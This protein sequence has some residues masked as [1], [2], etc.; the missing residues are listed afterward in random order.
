MAN[1][2]LLPVG[3]GFLVGTIWGFVFEKTK[4]YI[5]EIVQDQMAMGNFLMMKVFLAGMGSSMLGFAALDAF[6]G[7]GKGAYRR[8]EPPLSLGSWRY[9][10]NL[11]GGALM[12]IGMSLGG[13]CP[14]TAFV[15]LAA[16]L[17]SAPYAIAGGL[18]GAL[19]FGY[20]HAPLRANVTNYL[21]PGEKK[22]LDQL[23]G[24]P[25][26]LFAVA[27][28]SA[29]IAASFSLDWL[30]GPWKRELA[31]VVAFSA[32][33]SASSAAS[34]SAAASGLLGAAAWPP[35]A[36]C[37]LFVLQ[38]LTML[39]VRDVIGCS[40]AY[41]TAAV[42]LADTVDS[43]RRQRA[44]YLDT[45][46]TA[47]NPFA[48]FQA[49]MVTGVFLGAYLSASLSD[50]HALLLGRA[51]SI[52]PL[53]AF[54]SGLFIVVG[55]RLADGCPSGHGFSGMGHLA[56]SSLATVAAMFAG[57]MAFIQVLRRLP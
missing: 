51:D 36:F 7:N 3:T 28:G 23:L 41:C 30:T 35:Q 15:Q 6:A 29:L 5:P 17:S 27:A 11:L 37:V 14:G 44:P 47:T 26:R 48:V 45:F 2:P 52:S 53:S 43:Q 50:P 54:F 55:A 33:S 25:Y 4:V 1:S 42:C 49:C 12:G 38:I 39:V 31:N 32:G 22:T 40:S 19:L 46:R 21:L 20:T 34:G 16:G 24:L 18:A 10:G 56:V 8:P 9:G 57:G 13:T